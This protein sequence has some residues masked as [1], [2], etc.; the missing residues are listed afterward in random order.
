MNKQQAELMK[1]LK[2]LVRLPEQVKTGKVESVDEGGFTIDVEV[3]GLTYSPV[4]LKPIIVPGIKGIKVIPAVGSDVLIGRI[5]N[6]ENWYCVDCT[7]IDKILVEIGEK[8]SCEI[9]E[10]GINLT[11]M[12]SAF[13][14]DHSEN[15]QF[16]DGSFGGLIKIEQMV[17]RM[18]VLENKLNS[19]IAKHNTHK[20]P[21]AA[22]PAPTT[23]PS[24]TTPTVETVTTL[25]TR[26]QIEN[27]KI[28]HG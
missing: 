18:N 22:V 25:T 20:H 17:N 21:V 14:V 23:I 13:T 16:N 15:F 5:N 4:R 12:G 9:T 10:N 11:I 28:T 27:D 8:L 7:T 3:D 6:S 26:Q 24:L 1:K 2:G 19:L